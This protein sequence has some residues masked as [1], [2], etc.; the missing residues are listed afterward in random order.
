MTRFT[1]AQLDAHIAKNPDAIPE[2]FVG[3]G[4]ALMSDDAALRADL[5]KYLSA[6][7]REH[8]KRERDLTVLVSM[9]LVYPNRF[10][11]DPAFLARVLP[12][13]PR[14]LD[15]ATPV[16]IRTGALRELNELGLDFENAEAVSVAWGLVPRTSKNK[17]IGFGGA[18]RMPDDL[19]GPIEASIFSMTSQFFKPEEA[20]AFLN[21]VRKASP[22]RRIV[23]LADEP[24]RE[25]LNDVTRVETFARPFTPW[26]RDPFTVARH[27]LTNGVVF[28]NRPNLQPEREEDANMVR[29]LV[30]A[31]PF[32]AQ[33]TV[34]PVPFHNGHVLL[35]PNAA[36]ISLHALEIRALQLLKIDKVPVETFGTQKGI[37]R[38]MT[39]IRI[40]SREYEG[41]YRRPIKFVHPVDPDPE[42][43]RKLGGGGGFDLD[44]VV[45]ML[46]QRDGSLVA[47][48][49]DI[50]L[51]AKLKVPRAYGVA[52][53]VLPARGLAAFLDVVAESLAAREVKVVRVP[54]MLV[55]RKPK[56]FLITWN[57]V[58]LEAT[59]DTLRAEGFASLIDAADAAAK[60]TFKAA[61]YELTLHP[62]LIQSVVL[63]GGYRCA[64]NHIR[65]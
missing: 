15:R 56:P 64:S 40:A 6:F 57:N 39:A 31:A 61:A 34:A 11:S 9:K 25:A 51:G 59:G 58:V 19:S 43:F 20:K 14:A 26:P 28:I 5:E 54:L 46:P 16:E 12:L 65:P 21:S 13:L 55:D 29:T 48:V 30:Q 4:N 60:E 47:L 52:G 27:T 32:D 50:S 42:L 3:F 18:V 17:R 36:W 62:P 44:S 41:L 1:P 63:S 45:T 24:M 2:I 53:E 35:T 37:E 7:H 49:G 38:Y 23:V 8:A 33:W 22:E 10:L